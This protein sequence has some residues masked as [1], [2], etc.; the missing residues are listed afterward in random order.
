VVVWVGLREGLFIVA[1]IAFLGIA[2]TLVSRSVR[3]L[4]LE[5]ETPAAPLG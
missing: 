2:A 5:P 3:R 1:C 4:S